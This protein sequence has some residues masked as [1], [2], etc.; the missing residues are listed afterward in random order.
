MIVV[1]SP[2]YHPMETPPLGNLVVTAV[3]TKS[4]LT[5]VS[6]VVVAA[7]AVVAFA[8]AADQATTPRPVLLA[9]ARILVVEQLPEA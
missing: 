4:P 5:K 1:R 6:A 2:S 9:P 3:E 8:V 7:A